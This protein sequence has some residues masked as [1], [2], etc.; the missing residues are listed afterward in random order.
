M[1]RLFSL[2]LILA[3]ALSLFS[4][5]VIDQINDRINRVSTTTND[6]SAV[7][8][9]PED[10]GKI[11]EYTGVPITELVYE[12]NTSDYGLTITTIRIDFI[13]NKVWKNV[14]I[15]EFNYPE[16]LH[17]DILE[18]EEYKNNNIDK[19]INTFTEEE[20]KAFIDAC[21]SYG[22]FHIDR[23]YR[24]DDIIYDGNGWE[25]VLNFEN[26][27]SRFSEGYMAGPYDIFKRC[28]SVFN[29]LCGEKVF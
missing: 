13:E 17:P 5:E 1:K 11:H 3:L 26:G 24:P 12:K 23:N 20:E 21:Y 6:N 29:G 14:Y 10:D 2:V 16:N 9:P 28:A 22:L 15:P 8:E 25:L 27:S 7:G 19:E 18:S 4:C